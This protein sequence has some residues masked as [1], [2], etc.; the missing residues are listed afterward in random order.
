MR[1]RRMLAPINSVKHYVHNTNTTLAS[2]A[3]KSLVIVDAAKAPAT[4]NDSDVK[5]GAVV[6]A[7]FI[8]QWIMSKAVTGATTQFGFLVE[9]VPANQASVTPAQIVTLNAYNNKKNILYFTQG[10]IGDIE[11]NSI[12][13]FRQWIL[14]PKGKQRF[15]L[16]D[17]L[18]ATVFTLGNAIQTCGFATFKEYI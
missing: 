18:V 9:K 3:V 10:V 14:I 2:N 11:T 13:V 7:V 8:E 12:P 16:S 15:G 6:K 17:R 5:E 4:T 1:H